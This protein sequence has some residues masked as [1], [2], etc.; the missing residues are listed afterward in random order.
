MEMET[1]PVGAILEAMLE[2]PKKRRDFE[3]LLS[4]IRDLTRLQSRV[5]REIAELTAKRPEVKSRPVSTESFELYA[6]T[7]SNTVTALQ[8]VVKKCEVDLKRVRKELSGMVWPALEQ[9]GIRKNG[10]YEVKIPVF[11]LLGEDRYDPKVQVA[12]ILG[13]TV[14]DSLADMQVVLEVRDSEGDAAM[15]IRELRIFKVYCLQEVEDAA[16]FVPG[17]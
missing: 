15:R 12:K 13:L 6:V 4:L 17:F 14:G 2:D 11:D 10:V 3:G 1:A 16:G 5:R 8:K 7:C 9:C